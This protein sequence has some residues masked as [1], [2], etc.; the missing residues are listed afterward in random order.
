MCVVGRRRPCEV[1]VQHQDVIPGNKEETR[2]L[3]LNSLSCWFFEVVGVSLDIHQAMVLRGG[4]G[5]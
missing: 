3:Y 4:S 2:N 1:M 5:R